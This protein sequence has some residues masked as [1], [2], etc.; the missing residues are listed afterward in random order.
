MYSRTPPLL[1]WSTHI[2]HLS[3]QLARY[4]G[5]FYRIRNLL[6]LDIMHMLYYCFIYYQLQ[7][8]IPIWENATKVN[9]KELSIRLNDIIRTM[10]ISSKVLFHDTSLQNSEFINIKHL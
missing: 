3:L 2:H 9:F 6:P 5:M 8:G 10:T 7:Y 4:A 1:K